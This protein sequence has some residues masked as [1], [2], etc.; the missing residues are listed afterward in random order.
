M[1]TVS[2]AHILSLVVDE[3]TSWYCDVEQV[4][5]EAH[6]R[7]VVDV[8]AMDWYW[9]LVHVRYEAQIRSDVVV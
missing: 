3:G 6:P 5:I 4:E 7:L 2:D 8:G 1:Q 9:V